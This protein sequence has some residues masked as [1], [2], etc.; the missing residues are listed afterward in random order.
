MNKC[1]KYAKECPFCKAAVKLTP[2]Y[3]KATAWAFPEWSFVV[4]ECGTAHRVTNKITKQDAGRQCSAYLSAYPLPPHLQKIH[5]S[6][7]K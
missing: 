6:E 3:V 1:P 2:K 5:C 4:Y 7:K